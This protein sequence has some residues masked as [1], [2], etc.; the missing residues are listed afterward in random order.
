MVQK[1]SNYKTAAAYAQ[2]W[3]GA[4]KDAKKQDIVFAEAKALKDGI[5][6]VL[7]LW[8]S[9]SSPIESDEDKLDVLRT[10][11]QKSGL[12]EITSETLKIVTENNRLKL[13]PLILDEFIRLYYKDKGIIEVYVDSAI[14]LSDEQNNKLQA[15]LEKKLNSAVVINYHVNPEV[16]G[17]LAVRFNSYLI[18]DTV[19]S[20]LEQVKKLLLE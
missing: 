3:F 18:D 1:V 7:V 6:N 9:M 11:A 4:A 8:D 12:S 17:G 20:K 15:V 2:A 13:F 10:L 19:C 16:L 5:E 14:K